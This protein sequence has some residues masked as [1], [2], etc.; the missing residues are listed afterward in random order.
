M[1]EANESQP[2]PEVEV[3]VPEVEEVEDLRCSS[4]KKDGTPCRNTVKAGETLCGSHYAQGL[5]KPEPR[6]FSGETKDSALIKEPAIL[7]DNRRVIGKKLGYGHRSISMLRPI[8]TSCQQRENT[9]RTWFL[10]C[11]HDP[12]VTTVR[13]PYTEPTYKQN[14]DGTMTLTGEEEKVRFVVRPNW[15]EVS[16]TPR[17]NGGVGPA[18]KRYQGFIRPSELKNTMYPYGIA[19]CC[20]WSDCKWQSGL[21]EYTGIE[22]RFCRELEARLAAWDQRKVPGMKKSVEIGWDEESKEIR[23]EQLAAVALVPIPS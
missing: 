19:E 1:N 13:I 3:E 16:V 18:K 20:E 21:V 9:P 12:Y 2:E 11:A 17:I 14:E 15:A 4:L 22:G 23:D 6:V 7:E 5:P 10:D 8:C